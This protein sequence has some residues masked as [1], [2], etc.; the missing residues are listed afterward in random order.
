M[1][2]DGVYEVKF[3]LVCLIYFP[4][5]SQLSNQAVKAVETTSDSLIKNVILNKVPNLAIVTSKM[6]FND[7]ISAKAKRLGVERL[8]NSAFKV[9]EEL[10]FD[11]YLKILFSVT[12]GYTNMA[13][14][15][16]VY[17]RGRPCYHILTTVRSTDFIS[18]F[19]TLKDTI[20]SYMDMEYGMTWYYSKRTREGGYNR[21]LYVYYDHLKETAVI[22]STRYEDE[23]GRKI[24]SAKIDTTSIIPFTKD[25]LS[26]FYF[27][28]TR[29]VK[30]GN[31]IY[32]PVN[33]LKTNYSLKVRVRDSKKFSVDAGD[34]RAYPLEPAVKGENIINNTDDMDVIIA[35][36]KHHM[37]IMLRTELA[38]GSVS[39][40]LRKY[41]GAVK[42]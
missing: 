6:T 2:S 36:E 4:L 15:D 28:R 13:I 8:N 11:I 10:Y 7:S 33:S 16:T 14:P 20:E 34:F 32:L 24:R 12:A 22:K 35:Q 27:L 29:D 19:Y 1:Y 42:K 21:D 18:N 30:A 39:V 26:A 37:P 38:I 5:Y 31:E 17:Y 41:R 23:K 40:E 9:G 3:V 25:I